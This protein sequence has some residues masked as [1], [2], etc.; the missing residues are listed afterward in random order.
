MSAIDYIY[1]YWFPKNYDGEIFIVCPKDSSISYDANIWSDEYAYLDSFGDKDLLFFVYGF[2]CKYYPNAKIRFS[3]SK[4]Y[5][6]EHPNDWKEKNLIILGGTSWG[7]VV[8][9]TFMHEILRDVYKDASDVDRP[10]VLYAIK[11]DQE[12]WREIRQKICSGCKYFNADCRRDHSICIWKDSG[13]VPLTAS[14]ERTIKREIVEAPAKLKAKVAEVR[15]HLSAD[16]QNR[17]VYDEYEGRYYIK[18]CISKDIGVFAAFQNPFEKRNRVIIINGSHTFGGVGAF[19]TFDI[20]K[21]IAIKNYE[22]LDAFL[23]NKG[24]DFISYFHVNIDD[25]A[26]I[27]DQCA[28]ISEENIISLCT[29]DSR[30]DNFADSRDVDQLSNKLNNF[31]NELESFMTEGNSDDEVSQKLYNTATDILNWINETLILLESNVYLNDLEKYYSEFAA[32]ELKWK[33][34]RG[35]A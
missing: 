26:V 7:H 25:T 19:R 3:F 16:E 9:R 6:N 4:Q 12:G 31:K 15:N 33:N 18:D 23:N 21:D 27:C 14:I 1:K 32:N 8:V 28:K 17:I 29:K 10:P 22:T 5:M 11:N 34:V 24:N 20:E 2:I 35:V 13:D 30:A